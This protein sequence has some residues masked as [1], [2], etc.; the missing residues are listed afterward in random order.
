MPI[1]PV[2]FSINVTGTSGE[3]F[4]GVFKVKPRLNPR[5][6]LQQDQIRRDLLGGGPKNAEPSQAASSTASVYSKI[7]AHLIE[8]PSWWK[9]A[10]N[11]IELLDEE[12]I[13]KVYDEIVRIE[14]EH[15]DAV[16]AAGVKA[17]EALKAG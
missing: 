17:A 4:K 11:G 6:V 7:W 13:V 12:P 3:V 5:E 15:I 8:A 16:K 14:K 1:I 10:Q 2:E 9:D